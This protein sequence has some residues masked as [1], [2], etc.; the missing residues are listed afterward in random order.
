MSEEGQ[1]PSRLTR[2]Q[3]MRRGAGGLAALSSLP[4]FLAACGGDDGGSVS[5]GGASTSA[6]TG[7]AGPPAA[8]DVK[9]DLVLAS[10]PDWYG[11]DLF[12][13][14][15]AKYPGATVK[16][17]T[18]GDGTAAQIAQLTKNKGDYDLTLAGIN[19]CE[20]FKLAGL[21]EP[22]DPSRVP[23]IELVGAEFR[24]AYPYGIPTD[25]GRTGFGY[26]KDL[27]SERPTTWKELWQ[28]AAKYKGKTTMLKYDSDIQ[29]MALKY[30]G[31]S[32]NTKDDG[33]L[34]AMQKALM[35]LKPNLKAII[36]TDFSKALIQG[37]V[38]FAID[39]DYDIALAQESNEDIVWVQPTEGVPAY[40]E[41][42]AALSDSE[43]LPAVWALMDFH[44]EPKNYASFVNAMGPAYTVQ[45]A[46][47]Y[48]RKSIRDNPILKYNE[49]AL[50]GVEFE[51]FLGPEQTAK[52]G[53][54]WEEFLAA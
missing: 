10:Y 27:I 24:K 42:W 32:V 1:R 36:D 20:Q 23:N 35:E 46:E 49:Q 2:R 8:A 47:K 4:A 40:L 14:F 17:A 37:D 21:L 5:A 15:A 6:S 52:R 25:F 51:G 16:Q 34:Q 30:L 33:E 50:E 3:A 26:R 38:F 9:G 43:H 48:I 29:G 45:S 11:P 44:L 19:A 28:L 53:K 41:G 7:A 18:D 54:M 22:F 39:Y 31:Y 13:D 12:K